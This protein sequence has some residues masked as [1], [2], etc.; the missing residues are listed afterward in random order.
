MSFVY[1][2]QKGAQSIEKTSICMRCGQLGHTTEQC[3]QQIPSNLLMQK[4]LQEIE[5]EAIQFKTSEWK[6]DDMGLFIPVE[7]RII[8]C[9]H[10]WKD[11]DFCTNCGLFGHTSDQC[12]EPDFETIDHMF[13]PYIKDKTAKAVEKKQQ[14]IEALKKFD[15]THH[16]N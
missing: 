14:I 7:K 16:I 13:A 12:T 5:N 15:E 1:K 9:E 4:Q 6:E 8:Q 2:S 3:T 11:G 10:T